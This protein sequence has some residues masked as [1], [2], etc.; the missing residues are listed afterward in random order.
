M[1]FAPPTVFAGFYSK[2]AFVNPP[3]Q[4]PS[5]KQGQQLSDVPGIG[6]TRLPEWMKDHEQYPGKKS[7]EL[8]FMKGMRT[9]TFQFSE[10]GGSLNCPDL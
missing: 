4:C 6:L 2:G 10:F 8:I 1:K 9:A 3:N 5:Y 7:Q